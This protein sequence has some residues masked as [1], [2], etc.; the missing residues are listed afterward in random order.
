MSN[1][2]DGILDAWL[3]TEQQIVTRLAV[4]LGKKYK[5]GKNV[6][7]GDDKDLIG[8]INLG[9]FQ[10]SGG[11]DQS[12]GY[13][14]GCNSWDTVGIFRG[15]F[16]DR[17]EALA[18]AVAFMS[19]ANVPFEG[20]L[21]GDMPNVVKV[22]LRSHPTTRRDLHTVANNGTPILA[23]FIEVTFGVVYQAL[24]QTE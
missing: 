24:V 23:T 9:V 22:Y 18:V 16:V 21:D 3:A 20:S 19:Q 14:R 6:F 4:I 13:D 12:Q 7:I 8:R 17:K 15:V 10:I 5:V 1:P 2:T 11:N